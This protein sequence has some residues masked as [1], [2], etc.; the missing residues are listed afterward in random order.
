MKKAHS[1]GVA[2]HERATDEF[3]QHVKRDLHTSHSEDYTNWDD[4]DE[5]ESDS[6][7]DDADARIG[8]PVANSHAAKDDSAGEANH[9]PPLRHLGVGFH[10]AVVHVEDAT[11]VNLVLL[12]RAEAVD[13]IPEAHD[14]FAVVV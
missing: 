1:Q 14:D 8:G 10:Q 9:I 13:E 7:E 6:I 5:A 3:G 11:L 4:E 2:L 12:G